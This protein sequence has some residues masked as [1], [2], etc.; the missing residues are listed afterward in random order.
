MP[1]VWHCCEAN[2]NRLINSGNRCPEHQAV[3]DAA[4]TARNYQRRIRDG[5]H[6]KAWKDKR[7]AVI[8]LAGGLCEHCGQ[9]ATSAHL[10]GGGDHRTAPITAFEATCHRCHGRIH[11]AG[12][13]RKRRPDLR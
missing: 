5:R 12:G 9:L 6:T 3:K 7:A 4:K 11:G 10:P 1:T 13:T 8:R 2:C